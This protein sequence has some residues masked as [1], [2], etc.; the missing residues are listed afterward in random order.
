M[1]DGEEKEEEN[2]P[3]KLNKQ[4]KQ[5][6]YDGGIKKGEERNKARGDLGLLHGTAAEKM[7]GAQAF[8]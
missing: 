1:G 2:G 8:G 3:K 7:K 6:L 5:L 4:I